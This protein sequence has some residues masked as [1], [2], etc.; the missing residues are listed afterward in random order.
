MTTDGRTT[1][2]GVF[3]DRA[4][5]TRAVEELYDHGFT[6]DQVGVLVP[7]GGEVVEAPEVHRRTR[8]E[9]GAVAGGAL[10]GLLGAAVASLVVPGFGPVIAGGLLAAALASALAGAAGGGLLGALVGMSI[11]EEDARHYE[12][13]FHSGRTLVTVR[14]EGRFDEASAILRQVAMEPEEHHRPPGARGRLGRLAQDSGG[15]SGGGS[16]FTGEE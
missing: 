1:A 4:H 8:A 2:V 9:E 5:A 3:Q 11:P 7:D 14:A 10:G 6:P 15:A 13:Q 16:V 12:R